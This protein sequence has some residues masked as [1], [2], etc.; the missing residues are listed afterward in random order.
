MKDSQVWQRLTELLASLTEDSPPFPPTLLYNEGWLLRLILDW[1][2]RNPVAAHPLTFTPGT[3]WFSEA[4]LPSAF[5]PRHRGD[6][7]S[8]THTH[9]DGVIGHF[10]IGQTGK[11][12]LRLL[13]DATQFVVLEAKLI[14]GLSART[15]RVRYFDQA[16][17][18][19][20]CIAETLRLS[21]RRP[22]DMAQLA[23]FIL[24]P[25]RTDRARHL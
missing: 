3:R 5:L 13:E 8:E 11:T 1:F 14:K 17:R 23:F 2:S 16:A 25:P 4:R 21:N 22:Q 15:S 10:R 12:D 7:L 6:P 19:V 18:N 9:A 20:A 24:A